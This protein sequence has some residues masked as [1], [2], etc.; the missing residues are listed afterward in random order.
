MA[1]DPNVQ[2][3]LITIVTTFITTCG[4]VVAAVV[5]SRKEK[6]KA[7]TAGVEAGLDE[8][9]MLQRLLRVLADN[10]RLEGINA[11]L[12]TELEA[13]KKE[14]RSLRAKLAAC[15]KSQESDQDDGQPVE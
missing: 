4:V 2:V 15:K 6:A 9:E 14:N 8:K 1:I 3:A 10:D 5:N 7:A 13:A 11:E 12:K